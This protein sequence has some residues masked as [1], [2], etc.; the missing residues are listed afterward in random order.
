MKADQIVG[1]IFGLTILELP[2][3]ISSWL[4]INSALVKI[5]R[6]RSLTCSEK[7]RKKDIDNI[8]ILSIIIIILFTLIIFPII[9][10]IAPQILSNLPLPLRLFIGFGILII[11]API[12]A[13]FLGLFRGLGDV[14]GA[15]GSA[16]KVIKQLQGY[17]YE[18]LEINQEEKNNNTKK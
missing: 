14:V 1:A 4:L 3:I 15:G 12:Y 8:I 17:I 5:N 2:L 13:C 7:D 9:I 16:S 18:A 6:I 10:T 11:Y